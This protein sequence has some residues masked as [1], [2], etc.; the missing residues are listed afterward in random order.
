MQ[1]RLNINSRHAITHAGLKFY[2]LLVGLLFTGWTGLLAQNAVEI[3]G[4][5]T[6]FVTGESIPG[7]VVKEAGTKN[8]TITNDNGVYKIK[9][10]SLTAKL[11]YSMLSYTPQKV[12]INGQ[13][14]IDIQM[15]PDIRSLEEVVVVGYGSVQKKNLTGAVNTI[16]GEELANSPV[17][18]AAEAL[19]GK[20]AGVVVSKSDGDPGSEIKI[21]V[22]GGGSITQDN[23][24]LYIIDGFQSDN[25]LTTVAPSD[26]ESM[27]ILKD[28][29]ATAIYGA[30]GANGVILVT[31]KNGKAGK[32][33]ISYDAFYGYKKLAKKLDLLSPYE[34]MLAQYELNSGGSGYTNQYGTWDEMYARYGNLKGYDWQELVFG[35]TAVTQQHSISLNGGT[36]KTKYNISYNHTDDEGILLKTG[37]V[38]N[39]I[40]FRFDQKVTDKLSFNGNVSYQKRK[41]QG[42]NQYGSSKRLENTVLYRPSAGLAG[43]TLNLEETDFDIVYGSTNSVY[44]PI[45]L[46]ETEYRASNATNA[47][48]N[49][50]I[51]YEFFK[52]LTFTASAGYSTDFNVDEAFNDARSKSA[53]DNGGAFGSIKETRNS[54]LNHSEVLNFAKSF[55]DN[56]LNATVGYEMLYNEKK[57]LEVVSYGF[58][59]ENLGVE[60]MSLGSSPSKPKSTHNEDLLVSW[61]G[62]V[63]YDFR[64]KYLTQFVLRQDGS[65]KF[66][67]DYKRALFPSVSVAWR[68]DQEEFM[69]PV[70]QISNLKLR[71]SYGESGNNR[72]DNYLQIATMSSGNYA[73][74]QTLYST[75]Y[76]S[77]LKNNKLR[78]ETTITSNIGVDL[79]FF[80][81][82]LS[83]TTDIYKNTTK[84]LLIN[85]NVPS[86]SG[87]E[88]QYINIGKTENKGIEFQVNT[89][90]VDNK[91][92]KWTTDFNISFNRFKVVELTGDEDEM[93]VT[94]KWS[95]SASFNDFKVEVGK[96]TGQIY[97][98]VTDGYYS[99]DEF[100][101]YDASSKKYVLKEG[102]VT[103]SIVNSGTIRPGEL[104][105]KDLNGDGTVNTEDQQVIGNTNPKH[106]GGI[107]NTFKFYGFDFSVF[108]N[109]SYGNQ[110]Y[111]ANKMRFASGYAYNQNMIGDVRERFMPFNGAGVFTTN[112]NELKEMNKNAKMWRL[113]RDMKY[114]HS[115]VVEDGSFLR[116]NTITL[117]YTLPKKVVK[118]IK[119][120]SMR[121]YSTLYNPFLFTNYSG[122]DPEVDT[123]RDFPL[124]PG[125][126]YSA[127]PRSRNLIFGVNVSF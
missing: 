29:S 37:Y 127:Y 20:V 71:L 107:N 118:K 121:V 33:S 17:P 65:S 79:G 89:V 55:G 1:K 10:T 68:V 125:V 14:K 44:N 51:T 78:W 27:T 95:S 66:G 77:S 94:S 106:T 105:L 4:S 69:K 2:L 21:R 11:E 117:G 13:A 40:R 35:Q 57:I 50:G 47:S 73:I 85:A 48:Y 38:R 119:I 31:T 92:F 67:S 49:G 46:Q 88:R 80:N 86:S 39:N 58:P 41:V 120:N 113:N 116:V 115:W 100:A 45:T 28:A 114:V 43:D 53:I 72:I 99:P 54:K 87:Y 74:G 108:M 60:N 76:V 34:F 24:P 7:V 6:D 30:R 111:N 52:G 18:T 61:L 102:V 26:I 3:T 64:G 122:F 5:V 112:L 93:Y 96:P 16:S 110:V 70:E 84:D 15:V 98:Y 19:T 56:N 8:T 9:V 109:W 32:V 23:S 101:S 126:D 81:N 62:R 97:G 82:R 90:N 12:D 59:E 75:S 103:N 91:N 25:G 22:R 83:I 123:R 36:E 124:T 42:G 63:M 104:K